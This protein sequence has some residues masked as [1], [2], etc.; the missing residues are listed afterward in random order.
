MS[1]SGLLYVEKATLKWETGIQNAQQLCAGTVSLMATVLEAINKKAGTEYNDF[2]NK[3]P[4]YGGK[5]DKTFGER[6]SEFQ[7]EL[8][9][10]Q[11]EFDIEKNG[12][13]TPLQADNQEL[14]SLGSSSQQAS[15]MAV[16][17]AEPNKITANL[18]QATL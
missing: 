1:Q 16:T 9:V 7:S 2:M 15:Q 13:N 17:V 5:K 6:M 8:N 4:K 10:L 18:L 3:V 11:S 12:W 14:Q